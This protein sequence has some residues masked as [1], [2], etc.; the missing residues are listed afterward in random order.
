MTQPDAT[1]PGDEVNLSQAKPSRR[2]LFGP[3][4]ALCAVAALS[5]CATLSGPSQV[6]ALAAYNGQTP[7][8]QIDNATESFMLSQGDEC[9]RIVKLGDGQPG[10]GAHLSIHGL[11]T[12]PSA[13]QPL[14][15]KAAAE[16]QAT[17]TFI[18]DDMHCNQAR[19]G[20]DLARYL[21][22]W[23]SQHHGQ[24]MTIETH[25]L[26]GRMALTALG[27]MAR[28]GTLP[29]DVVTLNM[30]SPPLGGFG[31]AN[32]CLT[33]P[34]PLARLIPGATPTR[35]M[36]TWSSGQKLLEEVTLPASVHTSIFYGTNDNLIDYTK[37]AHATI[38]NNLHATVYYL[39]GGEHTTTVPTVA[40]T[41]R[42]NFSRQELPY[43]PHQR[44]AQTDLYQGGQ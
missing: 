40:T 17:S 11:G 19:V 27:Q 7:M 9:G 41:P 29:G 6:A 2:S 1:P 25:S 43:E 30:I 21:R 26:G 33:M 4:L 36:A 42:Q 37:P 3:G 15:D 35:D 34:G 18:Y 16:G 31:F 44:A 23:M 20:S 12:G 28:D 14:I 13:M 24:P 10:R 5:G 38:E 22:G 32:I 8:T 39:A